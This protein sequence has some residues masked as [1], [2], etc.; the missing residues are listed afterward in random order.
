MKGSNI[1][2]TQNKPNQE[3]IGKFDEFETEFSS[4]TQTSQSARDHHY[5]F[6]TDMLYRFIQE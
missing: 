1:M 6:V 5:Y 4:Q 3:E 2:G